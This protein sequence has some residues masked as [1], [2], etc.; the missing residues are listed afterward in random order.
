MTMATTMATAGDP[1]PAVRLDGV[2]RTDDGKWGVYV[3]GELRDAFKHHD[4][5]WRFMDRLSGEAVSP[6]EKRTDFGFRH[7]PVAPRA[8]EAPSPMRDAIRKH[9]AAWQ[10]FQDA[11]ED[12]HP[13]AMAASDHEDE[14][15]LE[16]LAVPAR[17]ETDLADLM[18]HLAWFVQ[19]EHQRRGRG[20]ITDLPFTIFTNINKARRLAEDEHRKGYPVFPKGSKHGKHRGGKRGYR[21]RSGGSTPAAR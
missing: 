17:D 9:R 2:Y 6:V 16:L 18:Q 19:E 8:A 21:P 15:L 13:D 12:D 14:V 4:D 10:A 7:S 3:A 1:T 11:P 5:A 20:A